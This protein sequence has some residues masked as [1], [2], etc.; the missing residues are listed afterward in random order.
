MARPQAK[1][2]GLACQERA[3]SVTVRG[4][5]AWAGQGRAGEPLVCR[6]PRLVGSLSAVLSEDEPHILCGERYTAFV[7]RL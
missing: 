5:E 3:G 6:A 4:D 2:K 7:C 1:V